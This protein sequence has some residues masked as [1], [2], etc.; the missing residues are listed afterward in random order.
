MGTS[1][2]CGLGGKPWGPGE[3]LESLSLIIW[4]SIYK[5]LCKLSIIL[6]GLKVGW[7]LKISHD[8]LL[9]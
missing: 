6:V 4:S 2:F 9:I 1:Y 3:I 7:S 8:D 5:V